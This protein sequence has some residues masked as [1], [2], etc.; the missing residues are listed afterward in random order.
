MTTNPTT[1]LNGEK[2]LNP[3]SRLFKT[4]ILSNLWEQNFENNQS[5]SPKREGFFKFGKKEQ[6]PVNEKAVMS[7]L[8]DVFDLSFPSGKL[9]SKI[10]KDIQNNTELFDYHTARDRDAIKHLAI[11]LDIVQGIGTAPGIAG[12]M[13][14]ASIPIEAAALLSPFLSV[15]IYSSFNSLYIADN[16]R[17]QTLENKL[18]KKD[19]HKWRAL[20]IATQLGLSTALSALG[21]IGLSAHIDGAAL[22]NSEQ[23]EML[24]GA[25]EKTEKKVNDNIAQ[26]KKVLM[27][28]DK[29][30]GEA[31]KLQTA[32]DGRAEDMETIKRLNAK[33]NLSPSEVEALKNAKGHLNN[34]DGS[35][36]R[37]N[38]A[39]KAVSEL[40]EKSPEYQSAKKL[41][42]RFAGISADFDTKIR[43][44]NNQ[45]L[46]SMGVDIQKWNLLKEWKVSNAEKLVISAKEAIK[47]PS[48]VLGIA[49]IFFAL[50][51]MSLALGSLLSK[52]D[53]VERSKI[54]EYQNAL[55]E[56][57]NNCLGEVSG[58]T[59]DR[60]AENN[61]AN[62][63]TLDSVTELME[64]EAS[65]VD[66]R[67]VK[68]EK[69]KKQKDLEN[70]YKLL[71][72]N[73]FQI[74]AQYA[75]RLRHGDIGAVITPI[76]IEFSEKIAKDAEEA[77]KNKPKV[78]NFEGAV[79]KA[80]NSPDLVA[81][82]K[83]L[84]E[85]LHKVGVETINKEKPTG[86]FKYVEMAGNSVK[87]LLNKRNGLMPAQG[88]EEIMEN[89]VEPVQKS[90]A[91]LEKLALT[92]I[93][94]K[95]KHEISLLILKYFRQ[96]P[97]SSISLNQV[98]ELCQ[99]SNVFSADQLVQIEQNIVEKDHTKDKAVVNKSLIQLTI[100]IGKS[101]GKSGNNKLIALAT[102]AQKFVNDIKDI[103][104]SSD[105]SKSIEVLYNNLNTIVK[106]M[107]FDTG[108]STS[109]IV[110]NLI[111][112][113]INS[114]SSGVDQDIYQSPMFQQIL[115]MKRDKAQ[116][117][118]DAGRPKLI[119]DPNQT[120]TN[121]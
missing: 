30:A 88:Y 22:S 42:E 43:E 23:T 48:A 13:A 19:S 73:E 118:L 10:L 12:I 1:N 4:N 27:Q 94:P 56:K 37:L 96:N 51:A 52:K 54:L 60:I 75:A 85:A 7:I 55:R 44:V 114:Y 79:K 107:N 14:A 111:E 105:T 61:A 77:N 100:D 45:D 83:G 40:Q 76:D 8:S 90:L 47:N 109:T 46:L 70:A 50:E 113:S 9:D 84:R 28:N 69:I 59:Q 104:E 32:V 31:K 29:Y 15:A 3:E 38:E 97:T 82:I 121:P 112:E 89:K 74:S 117:Q 92:K 5:A 91:L 2:L 49:G 62:V 103:I 33:T 95:I 20:R 6:V 115:D 65:G 11:S 116:A 110:Q 17:N 78:A 63:Y 64:L 35:E 86:K 101:N 87:R 72:S 57:L 98:V 21:P 34:K 41:A 66:L 102:A 106:N 120:N 108:P 99:N 58:Y 25:K 119:I 67:S 18:N 53:N 26:S 36:T 81:T 93:N 71:S 24:Q 39:N 68:D 16:L 80:E